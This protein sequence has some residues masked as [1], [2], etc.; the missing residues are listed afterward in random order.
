MAILSFYGNDGYTLTCEH[1]YEANE[2]AEK[3]GKHPNYFIM[4]PVEGA[5][6]KFFMA[7]GGVPFLKLICPYEQGEWISYEEDDEDIALYKEWKKLD[8]G[9]TGIENI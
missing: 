2:V 1:P 5:T 3:L 8:P 4:G 7:L 6:I 9:G